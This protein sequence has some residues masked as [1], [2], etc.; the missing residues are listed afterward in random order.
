MPHRLY[1]D[2]ARRARHRCEYC[3]APEAV[4]NLEFEVDHIVP[5]GRG[6]ADEVGNLALACRSCNGR[7]GPAQRA[8]DPKTA[9]PMVLFDPRANVWGEH[10]QINLETFQIEGLTPVGR[11][12]VRRLGMNRQ[13]AVRARRLWVTRLLLS[14]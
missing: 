3:H 6:G 14:F 13:T 10:F 12:T 5:R 4:F 11:A 8:R 7:K 9:E 2:V 1:A